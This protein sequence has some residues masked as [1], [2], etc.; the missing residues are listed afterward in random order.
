MA[1]TKNNY[2]HHGLHAL[3][4]GFSAGLLVIS[5][6]LIAL[7]SLAPAT[8]VHAG[9]GNAPF[10]S[11]SVWNTALPRYPALATNTEAITQNIVD[12][13]AGYGV[14]VDTTDKGSPVYIA[15]TA[16]PMVSVTPWG[17]DGAADASLSSDWASVPIPFYALPSSGPNGR[18]MVS[19]PSTQTVWEFSRMYKSG[20][21]WF[22]CHGGQI[23]NTTINSGVFPNP[24]GV[25]TTGLALLAGQ[26]SI[27]DMQSGQINH[28]IGLSLPQLGGISWPAV[29]TSGGSGL[30][31]AG[32]RLQLDPSIDVNSLGLSTYGRM[33][34]RAAQI[35][36]FVVW[37]SASQVSITGENP[38]TDTSHGAQNP[39]GSTSL[40]SFPWNKLRALPVDYGIANY[41]PT[42]SQFAVSASTIAA[43]QSV[44]LS[45]QAV[46][47][48]ECA[49]PGVASHLGPSGTVNT[50]PLMASSA[51][52]ISCSGPNGS[53]SRTLNVMMPT[54]EQALPPPPPQAVSIANPVSGNAN[55]IGDLFNPS[56]LNTVY[57]VV[58]YERGSL[59]QVTTATPFALKTD[60]IA[61][62]HHALTAHIFY[63]DGHDDTQNIAVQILN[64]PAAFIR[65]QLGA[66]V[67]S[68]HIAA[69]LLVIGMLGS[70][71]VM[72][73]SAYWGWRR[74]HL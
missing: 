65:P 1:N 64:H 63:R 13:V 57:K 12:Q 42:L 56:V 50:T 22:A 6:L 18:M 31:A 62:G 73:A 69:P 47:I 8:L 67:A 26:V 32:M 20:G 15:D 16:T 71:G 49:I 29:R 45:W 72:T 19:Q 54:G 30:A 14:Q 40:V 5:V 36:G 43:G 46:N 59:L 53:V 17:C 2:L 61:D 41:L 38:L 74:A 23:T 51:F 4:F 34:A 70:L 48:S 66:A 55:V 68:S 35:Y 24:H 60:T 27:S 33:V 10:S 25:T 3:H 9:S 39:Y 7:Y 58:F 11:G 21:Q 37:D 52:S 44:A 28:A